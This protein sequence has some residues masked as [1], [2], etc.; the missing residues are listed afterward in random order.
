MYFDS[1]RLLQH[2]ARFRMVGGFYLETWILFCFELESVALHSPLDLCIP[3]TLTPCASCIA[4]TLQQ[5]EYERVELEALIVLHGFLQIHLNFGNASPA[6]VVDCL[7][8]FAVLNVIAE[9]L[10]PCTRPRFN[11]LHLCSRT[12]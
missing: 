1:N 9:T 2:S 11:S 5:F 12:D 7:T 4:V 3:E 8:L 10:I 6:F